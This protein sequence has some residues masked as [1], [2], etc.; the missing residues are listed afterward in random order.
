MAVNPTLYRS[1]PFNPQT[2]LV[3]V[4]QLSAFP[5]VL[6][7]NPKTGI[8][9]VKERSPRSRARARA[10]WPLPRRATARRSTW[11]ASCSTPWSGQMPHIPYRGA[12]PALNDLLG[13]QVNVMFDVLGSSLPYIQSG[14]LTPLA[15]TSSRR[16]PSLPEVPTLAEAGLPGYEFTGW[17]GIAAR[18][19]T[20][21][22]IVDRLNGTLNAILPSPSSARS[23]RPSAPRWW[24][25]AR[26][27]S[28]S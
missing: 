15:V 19:G 1:M 6:E 16:V 27:S 3:P 14:R 8:K 4:I 5:L 10:S 9:S 21:Q 11:P 22:P 18:A 2:D 20:P 28:A 23:G 26:P 17:H 24:P 25:A 7:V 13:G 12:G